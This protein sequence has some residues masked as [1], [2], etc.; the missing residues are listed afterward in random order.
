MYQPNY[1]TEYPRTSGYGSQTDSDPETSS[2]DLDVPIEPGL[3]EAKP[4]RPGPGF[5]T[6]TGGFKTE[7]RTHRQ[8]QKPMKTKPDFHDDFGSRQ[9][10][11][12]E[13]TY[14]SEFE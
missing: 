2:V 3:D 12:S 14:D 10:S 1:R 7:I 9:V 5:E 4:G 13:G 11:D 6:A 8:N